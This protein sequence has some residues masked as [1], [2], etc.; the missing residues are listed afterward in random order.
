MKINLNTGS[1][2]DSGDRELGSYMEFRLLLICP[3]PLLPYCKPGT[4]QITL[5]ESNSYKINVRSQ[6]SPKSLLFVKKKILYA[7]PHSP[8]LFFS[9]FSPLNLK[10]RG[11]FSKTKSSYSVFHILKTFIL[12]KSLSI[13]PRMY[14]NNVKETQN[15]GVSTSYRWHETIAPLC[16]NNAPSFMESL[17][18]NSNQL[19]EVKQFL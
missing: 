15:C 2:Q 9:V 16:L 6:C 4:I 18:N 7:R 10:E 5:M 14:S 11:S 13:V 12:R 1:I 17:P 19:P 8:E 3:A